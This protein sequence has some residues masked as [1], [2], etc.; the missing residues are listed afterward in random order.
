MT[1]ETETELRIHAKRVAGLVLICESYPPSSGRR[2]DIS[3]G[4]LCKGG[5]P[6]PTAI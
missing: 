3:T 2:F 1:R 6:S 5:L 4:L